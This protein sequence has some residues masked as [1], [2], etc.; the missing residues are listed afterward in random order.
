M[1]DSDYPKLFIE[2]DKF[3]IESQNSFLRK[4]WFNGLLGL[5]SAVLTLVGDINKIWA[6]LSILLILFLTISVWILVEEKEE[7]LWYKGRALAESIKSLTWKYMIG[8]E[9]FT[10]S[11]SKEDIDKDFIEKCKSLREEHKD[12]FGQI[13][14]QNSLE[15]ITSEMRR[16]RALSFKDRADYYLKNRIMP[17]CDWYTQKAEYNRKCSK[18][19]SSVVKI[20]LVFALILAFSKVFFPCKYYPIEILLLIASF[21]FTWMQVKKFNELGSAYSLT[22][23]EITDVKTLMESVIAANDNAKF[24]EFISDAENVF[25]REHTQWLARRDMLNNS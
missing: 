14:T 17:Q 3:S 21:A 4:V 19:W 22:A 20:S 23:H 9:P 10:F 12:L 25:S 16:V 13:Q 5:V 24:S 6:L 11:V 7:K 2:A 8:G 15:I 1:N 18:F